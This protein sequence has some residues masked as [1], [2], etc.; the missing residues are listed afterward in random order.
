MQETEY[1]RENEIRSYE[2]QEIM[3]HIPNWII[4]WGISLVFGI[5]ILFLI[6]SWIIKYPDVIQGETIVTTS[7]PPVKLVVKSSGELE[8]LILTDNSMVE[9][10]QTIASI[11]STL[12]DNAKA[13]LVVELA[14]VRKSYINNSLQKLDLKNT[15]M[16]FGDLQTN[17]SILKNALKNYKYLINDDNTSFNMLNVSQQIKNQKAL[18]QLISKELNS[19]NKLVSNAGNKFKSDKTL[20]EKGVISQAEFFEREKAYETAIGEIN[21]LEKTKITTA[22]TITD[23]E[24]QLNDLRF[25]FEQRKK[26]LL[27]EIDT[28]LSVLEN[29]LLTW[30]RNYQI[31]SPIKGKLTYL[32][33]LSENQF[34]EQGKEL[35]AVIPENQEYVAH[36]KIPKSGYGKVKVG[37]KVMLKID[38]FPS[39]EYGQLVGKVKSVSLIAAEKS[40][41]VNV[42]LLNGLKTTYHKELNYIPEM[43]GSA[44]IITEDL[45]ITDR[46]FNQFRKI[47]DR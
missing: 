16:L 22:I 29:A 4:R 32:L 11:K 36:L 9:K 24:K 26:T 5:I 15:P 1:K 33:T 13:Y 46:I 21:N 45:R 14:E 37:Q 47:F 20:Y 28:Q 2:V 35:F 40:Y 25:N 7:V 41:L 30:S 10:N 17:Y 18:M 34:I 39:H 27:L 23:L 44:E 3:S 42:K 8:H 12:S 43:S 6:L 19:V 38:N 31:V